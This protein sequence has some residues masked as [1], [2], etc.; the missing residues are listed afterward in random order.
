[1]FRSCGCLFTRFLVRNL[2]PSEEGGDKKQTEKNCKSNDGNQLQEDHCL[3][4]W[5]SRLL[6]TLSTSS[7]SPL[8]LQKDCNIRASSG[9]GYR[10]SKYLVERRLRSVGSP[11]SSQWPSS[12]EADA[13]SDSNGKV[14]Q[15]WAKE[16][17]PSAIDPRRQP[18]SIKYAHGLGLLGL[19]REEWPQGNFL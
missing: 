1:M 17:A 3:Y 8:H 2:G 6:N 19:H 4:T 14:D 18:H 5:P 13:A 12:S 10:I 11:S 7:S 15:R 9:H 16:I